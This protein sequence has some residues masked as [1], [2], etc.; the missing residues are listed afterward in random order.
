MSDTNTE[1]EESSI[2][3][4]PQ[5]ITPECFNMA[6]MAMLPTADAPLKNLIAFTQLLHHLSYHKLK[7]IIIIE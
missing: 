5:L 2:A 7:K 6:G 4:A 1:N 3:R